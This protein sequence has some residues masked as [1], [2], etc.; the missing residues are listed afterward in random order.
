MLDKKCKKC[1][2]Y[3]LKKNWTRNWKQRFKCRKCGYVFENKSRKKIK[4][5][6]LDYTEW[7]Q[8]YAQLSDK[9]WIHKNT[10]KDR[11]DKFKIK[12]FVH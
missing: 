2:L 10:V 9:Y 5:L 3:S 4:Q 8:T 6:W 12:K 7:K 1:G 11:L